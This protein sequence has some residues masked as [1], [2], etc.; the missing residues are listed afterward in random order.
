MS[1]ETV[2]LVGMMGAGKST[3]GKQLAKLRKVDFLDTDN[4]VMAKAGRGIDQIFE[5]LGERTFRWFERDAITSVAGRKA[6]VA[7]GGGAL[8]W[9]GA[10]R[11]RKNGWVVYL[12]ARPETLARRWVDATYQQ[13]RLERLKG[14]VQLA[15]VKRSDRRVKLVQMERARR[16]KQVERLARHRPLIKDADSTS[17]D[18]VRVWLAQ[19][20]AEREPSYMRSDIIVDT[21]D[22]SPESLAE[23]IAQ[24]LQQKAPR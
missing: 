2:W 1:G 14:L 10:N 17:P 24:W 5:D 3:V 7:L 18:Q 15:S 8:L 12:R 6:V 19:L 23:E 9:E 11:L 13:G 16:R 21:D 20:L 22:R 4:M